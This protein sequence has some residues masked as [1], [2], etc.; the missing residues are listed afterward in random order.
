MDLRKQLADFEQ[1]IKP[2]R[3]ATAIIDVAPDIYAGEPASSPY[4][5]TFTGLG[6]QR[7]AGHTCVIKVSRV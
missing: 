3:D 7:K 2:M 6:Y 5:F 4:C 1:S